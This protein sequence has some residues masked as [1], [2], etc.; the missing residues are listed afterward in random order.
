[1][2][3]KNKTKCCQKPS[4]SIRPPFWK[5]I[6]ISHQYNHFITNKTSKKPFGVLAFEKLRSKL[7]LFYLSKNKRP[8]IKKKHNSKMKRQ[9][10]VFCDLC[11]IYPLFENIEFSFSGKERNF[12]PF[13]NFCFVIVIIIVIW[14]K[15]TNIMSTCW[16]SNN[17]IIAWTRKNRLNFI[18]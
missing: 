8:W 10:W 1:M 4:L 11:V 7:Q 17:I 16:W 13:K 3:K 6:Y 2:Q 5:K 18:S 9:I 14:K 12:A 15:Q